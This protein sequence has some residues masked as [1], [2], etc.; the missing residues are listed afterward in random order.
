MLVVLIA[1]IIMKKSKERGTN[2]AAI[3][4][5]AM[6]FGVTAHHLLNYN[7][8]REGGPP[9]GFALPMVVLSA[10]TIELMFKCILSLEGTAYSKTHHLHSLFKRISNKRKARIIQLWDQTERIVVE[11]MPD[12]D[13][14]KFPADLPSALKLCSNTFESARYIYEPGFEVYYLTRFPQLLQT[15]ILEARPDWAPQSTQA[16]VQSE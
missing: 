1:E 13:G 6:H 7:D 10:F 12:V 3:Y 2:P 11:R 5:Y 14:R 15:V 8:P 9:R 16:N 4:E